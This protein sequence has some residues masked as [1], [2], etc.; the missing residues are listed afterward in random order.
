MHEEL[1]AAAAD[2][3][4]ATWEANPFHPTQI[5]VRGYDDRVP[6]P[7]EAGEAAIRDRFADIA[8]RVEAIAPDELEPQ[9]RITRSM[10][11]VHGRANVESL[12][13]RATEFT[14]TPFFFGAQ[15]QLLSSLP[16]FQLTSDDQ[17]RDYVTRLSRLPRFLEASLERYRQGVASG[18]TA[19]ARGIQGSIEQTDRYLALPLHEDPL[20]QPF[21]RDD[22]DPAWRD[23]GAA[24]VRDVLR[25]ALQRY[26]D[27]LAADVLPAGRGDERSGLVH[28]PDG[29]RLYRDA[30]RY[31]TTTDRT[32]QEVHDLG[33]EL[34]D[35]LR[36]EYAEAGASALGTS[37]VDEVFARLR[38]DPSLRYADPRDAEAD[39]RRAV[40]KAADAVP[41]WFGRLPRGG[42][43]VRAMPEVEARGMTVAYYNP[44]AEDGSSPG[45][46][47]I[48]T[49]GPV[50]TRFEAEA[51]AYHEALPGHHLQIAIQQE[52]EGIPDFRRIAVAST[53]FVEGWGLYAERLADEMG[54]YTDAIARLGM[55]ACDSLRACRLVVD[56]GLHALGWTRQQSIDFMLANSSLSEEFAVQE[57]DRYV[58]Y[59]GQAC[60]Y[61][62]GRLEILR[63]RDRARTALGGGFALPAFHDVVLG[64]GSLPLVT[65]EEVVDAWVAEARAVS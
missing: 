56:T 7:S 36:T 24:V 1:E 65:L 61:M 17:A 9:E 8:A 3:V 48:N 30:L 26:R 10:L 43:Q 41:G 12:E 27:G 64:S 16:K 6:D 42:C 33:L 35:Q 62:L 22:L 32:P 18:R 39:A 57:V 44:P 14:I 29:E 31:H 25:P 15:A 5:G 13:S 11:V 51:V 63:L 53:A 45:T 49:T 55:L 34:L 58:V 50:L 28:L 20:L 59:P 4:A 2:Y 21:A 19:V 46:Y 40:A 37:D 60:A 52:L 54:L 23:H 38:D 47:W